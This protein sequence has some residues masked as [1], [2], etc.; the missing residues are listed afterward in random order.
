MEWYYFE[1]YNGNPLKH[2][3][4]INFTFEFRKKSKRILLTRI[5]TGTSVDKPGVRIV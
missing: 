5:E 4:V 1:P 3:M 2:G